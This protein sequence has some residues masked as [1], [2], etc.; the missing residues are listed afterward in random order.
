MILT[1]NGTGNVNWYDM[2]TGGNL[3]SAGNVLVTPVLQSS[4]TYYAE[5]EKVV[6]SQ[7]DFV[8]PQNH[9]GNNFSGNTYNGYI[10][11]DAYQPFTLKSVKVYTDM[12]GDR[13]IELRNSNGTVLQSQ[14]VNIP[15][16]TS[17]VTL[18]FQIP[19]GTGLQLGTNESANQT[20]FGYASPRLRRSDSAVSYPY[21]LQGMVSLNNSPYGNAYYYYF[22]DWEIYTSVS[23]SSPR[24]AVTALVDNIPN[25]SVS[26]LDTIYELHSGTYT[27]TGIPS[28][29]SFAGP[30]MNGNVFNPLD[31]GVGSHEIIYTYTDSVSGCSNFYKQTVTVYENPTAIKNQNTKGIIQVFPNPASSYLNIHLDNFSEQS[32]VIK[33]SNYLGAVI[34]EKQFELKKHALSESINISQYSTGVYIGE[35]LSGSQT[36]NFRFLKQ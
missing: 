17:R 23:C 18:N 20:N 1:A 19:A 30:G 3:I 34:F 14:T 25:V 21:V 28:G 36:S 8:Q 35:I 9:S 31:A 15:S 27:V 29:G 26:G 13:T 16:G 32:A 4:T 33:I 11:F 5:L 2:P 22:Y 10:I 7:T 24:A 12:A 6:A